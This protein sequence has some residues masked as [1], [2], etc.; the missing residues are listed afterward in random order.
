M[1]W[2][3]GIGAAVIALILVSGHQTAQWIAAAVI[4]FGAIPIYHALE[5]HAKQRFWDEAETIIRASSG[6]QPLEVL[7]FAQD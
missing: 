5:R 1:Q 2:I 3:V 7:P 6:E 4:L